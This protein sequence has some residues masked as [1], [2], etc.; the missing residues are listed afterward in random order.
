M[1]VV[2]TPSAAMALCRLVCDMSVRPTLRHGLAGVNCIELPLAVLQANKTNAKVTEIACR[3]ISCVCY[4]EELSLQ[5]SNK[6]KVMDTIVDVLH[7]HYTDVYTCEHAFAAVS[8]LCHLPANATQLTNK[9]G[10]IMLKAFRQHLDSHE[11]V[12]QA[13]RSFGVISL[14][15][16][17]L[18][19]F[20]YNEA[21][22]LLNNSIASKETNL[23]ILC[24]E[25]LQC[26]TDACPPQYMNRLWTGEAHVQDSSLPNTS[27]YQGGE[28][29]GRHV[30]IIKP[31][32]LSVT[33]KPKAAA[34]VKRKVAPKKKTTS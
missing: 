34:K 15:N 25:L 28:A 12:A 32:V 9:S 27:A 10:V 16:Q 31:K 22:E 21:L 6:I 20:V 5:H 29:H 2:G 7:N 1:D 24:T 30:N 33:T 14:A 23:R 17:T 4:E 3:A 19:E 13:C 26:H 11:L 18:A 8:N